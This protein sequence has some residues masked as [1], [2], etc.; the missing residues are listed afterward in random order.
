MVTVLFWPWPQQSRVPEKS[1]YT[2]VTV[3]RSCVLVDLIMGELPCVFLV[4]LL[5]SLSLDHLSFEI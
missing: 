5:P 4:A 1:Q 2:Q 3:L